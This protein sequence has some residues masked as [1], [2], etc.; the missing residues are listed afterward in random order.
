VY[1]SPLRRRVVSA[2]LAATAAVTA[3]L[4]GSQSA[5]G[6]GVTGTSADRATLAHVRD[7]TAKYRDVEVALADG[8]LPT[9]DCVASPDGG[10]GLHYVK[11]QL[12]GVL[13]PDHPAVLLYQADGAHRTL[14]G[15]EWFHADAD[16][17]LATDDDRPSLFG[18]AFQGPMLGHEPGMPIHYDLHV[19]AW[20]ANPSGDF[21]PW[22]PSVH[23]P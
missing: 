1:T 13:D 3:A 23:C 11:P 8:Y 21:S 15:A 5:A 6:A 16:Q 17:D 22:N 19:W 4:A 9:D 18:H 7:I 20:H 12:L 2:T 14:M 10:M